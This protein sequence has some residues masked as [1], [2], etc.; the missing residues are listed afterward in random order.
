MINLAIVGLVFGVIFLAELPDKSQF[1]TLFL[2]M[3][4]RGRY[5]WAG[6]AAAFALHVIIAVT[7]AQALSLLSHRVL[8][9]VV[10]ALFAFGAWLLL[11]HPTDVKETLESK[12]VRK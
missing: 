5:V 8:D 3:R 6:A 1:A 9:V 11:L 7:A 4:Y 12:E 10:A 2:S